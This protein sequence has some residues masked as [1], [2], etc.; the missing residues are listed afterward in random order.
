MQN[1]ENKRENTMLVTTFCLP[2]PKPLKG[3]DLVTELVLS[4][5]LFCLFP[6][7]KPM[8]P[9]ERNADNQADSLFSLPLTP[10]SHTFAWKH[11]MIYTLL[12]F[13]MMIE[14]VLNLQAKKHDTSYLPPSKP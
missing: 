6:W 7:C 4:T 2:L 14:Q 12:L 1:I 9:N 8:H 13:R 10:N 5:A 11:Q 3:N